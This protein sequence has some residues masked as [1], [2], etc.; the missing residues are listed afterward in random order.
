MFQI[1]LIITLIS[2]IGLIFLIFREI[3]SLHAQIRFIDREETQ[4]RFQ[5]N[6]PFAPFRDLSSALNDHRDVQIRRQQIMNRQEKL[7]K[8]TITGL[9]HDIRTPLTSIDGYLQ[10][11]EKTDNPEDKSRYIRV[12]K[13]RA[14]S[15]G[16]I[17][18][19]LFTFAKLQEDDYQLALETVDL[20]DSVAHALFAFYEDFKRNHFEPTIQL[21][22]CPIHVRAQK[23]ALDRILQNLLKNA[24]EHGE[25]ELSLSLEKELR[26]ALLTCSNRLPEQTKLSVE[27]IFRQF[28][29]AAPSRSGSST[30]LGLSI[31]KGLAE[32]MNGSLEASIEE[33][34]FTIRLRL[35]IEESLPTRVNK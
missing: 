19:E 3:R 27:D 13:S 2:S 11:L 16:R 35:P 34:I 26:Q 30:G 28:Y 6:L 9:S 10:L 20:N 32:K 21:P 1:I 17:L 33:R 15:L 25:R 5:T 7:L 29:K 18:D 31:A 23:Q 24:F 12:M 22:D 14:E 8:E 4:M